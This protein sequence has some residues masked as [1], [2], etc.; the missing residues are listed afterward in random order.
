[1]YI[2]IYIYIGIFIYLDSYIHS[3]KEKRAY[4][5]YMYS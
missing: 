2:Y 1:M 4:A 3:K 5:S